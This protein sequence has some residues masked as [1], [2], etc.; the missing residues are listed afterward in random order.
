VVGARAALL[1]ALA[2]TSRTGVGSAQQAT[3]SEAPRRL[4]G[5]LSTRLSYVFDSN[6]DHSQ[7]GLATFGLLAGLG[8]ECR[9]RASGASFELQYDG[10]FRRYSNSDIWSVPGHDASVSL[11]QRVGRHWTVGA[12][13]EVAINGSAEDRV[14]RN[15][16]SVQPQ[17]EYRFNPATRLRL[18]GEYLLKRYPNPLG[19]DAFDPRIGIQFRQQL[20][21]RWSWAV[22]GRYEYNRADSARYRY[23]GPTLGLDL[24]NPAGA[25][26]RLSYS[27]RYRARRFTA[28][29]VSMNGTEVPRRD[30]DWV[31]SVAWRQ[32]GRHW[33]MAWSYQYER[34]RSNDTRRE[35]R[36]HIVT[37]MLN[38]SW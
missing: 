15:E 33:E 37:M 10:V 2:V 3:R 25:G 30:S 35:F 16:Y 18:Y 7:S 1:I 22:S 38:R 6:I 5:S 31:A 4:W 23:I 24:T 32:E 26:G 29:T 9:L 19:Q 21:E 11:T 14:L 34:F 36:E 28:R 8:G 13:G 20:G 17:L 27:V 12:A